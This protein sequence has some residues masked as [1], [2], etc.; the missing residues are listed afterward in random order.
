MNSLKPDV[1]GQLVFRCCG[2]RKFREP[3]GTLTWAGDCSQAGHSMWRK[4]PSSILPTW[5]GTLVGGTNRNIVL[6]TLSSKESERKVLQRHKFFS[7]VRMGSHSAAALL[8]AVGVLCDNGYLQWSTA[9]KC[10]EDRRAKRWSSG[11]N[12][13]GRMLSAF[14]ILRSWRIRTGIRLQGTEPADKFFKTCLLRATG[15]LKLMGLTTR[16]GAASQSEW[17][18]QPQEPS[19]SWPNDCRVLLYSAL[20]SPASA[21]W[22]QLWSIF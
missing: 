3:F 17:E 10:S 11:S 2:S 15:Y 18:G 12:R 5:M 13:W 7:T 14:G 8:R 22:R 19:F 6:L 4:S 1:T 20:A 9:N 16:M 21:R